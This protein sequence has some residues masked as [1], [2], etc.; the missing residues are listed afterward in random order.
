MK[1]T[2]YLINTPVNKSM[3][4]FTE[5]NAD[6]YDFV[7]A[8]S[9]KQ[10]MQ[11][12]LWA[13]KYWNDEM[14]SSIAKRV[15]FASFRPATRYRI[16]FLD[17]R[18]NQVVTF[19]SMEDV[20]AYDIQRKTQ[21][22]N[23]TFNSTADAIK[24]ETDEWLEVAH[25]LTSG[26]LSKTLWL[27]DR[28]TYLNKVGLYM[29]DQKFDTYNAGNAVPTMKKNI[30]VFTED[31]KFFDLTFSKGDS[32]YHEEEREAEHY[33]VNELETLKNFCQCLYCN[34]YG[35]CTD[36]TVGNSGRVTR[37]CVESGVITYTE[38]AEKINASEDRQMYIDMLQ[39]GAS[40]EDI[41]VYFNLTIVEDE[42]ISYR[43]F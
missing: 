14:K 40:I 16:M 27:T 20:T 35:I 4:S 15:K 42:P 9:A 33:E 28:A 29:Q 43:E 22:A 13:S 32:T 38:L 25:K 18:N 41:A 34:A 1:T 6:K 24:A 36:D 8:S 2:V 19:K 31:Y 21:Q 23:K 37:E 39:N 7:S 30:H 5:A 10:D 17:L 26:K 3:N 11:N 12:T